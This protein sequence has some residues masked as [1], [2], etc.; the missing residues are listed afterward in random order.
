[1]EQT[2]FLAKVQFDPNHLDPK[3]FGLNFFEPKN[4][5][6]SLGPKRSKT[7]NFS[8][9]S[10]FWT[11]KFFWKSFFLTK[12][13]FRPKVFFWIKNFRDK[14][15]F[16]DPK[17]AKT[18]IILFDQTFWTNI[19]CWTNFSFDKN[20][21]WPKPLDPKTFCSYGWCQ[22]H[23]EGGRSLIFSGGPEPFQYF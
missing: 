2:S 22:K 14:P 23:Q 5:W 1:M 9:V 8:D 18:Q 6:T 13:F 4:F 19:F 17:F 7:Q 21:V 12:I 16:L 11:Q 20:L 15:S 10:F 3:T